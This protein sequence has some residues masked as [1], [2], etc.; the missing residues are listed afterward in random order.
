MWYFHQM[1]P[2]ITLEYKKKGTWYMASISQVST[3]VEKKD[4]SSSVLEQ[5]VVGG[6][7]GVTRCYN[8]DFST[9]V[10]ATWNIAIYFLVG[11]P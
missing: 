6:G 11:A 4:N 1:E 10:G 7:G 3:V 9:S 8:F 2:I 5:T